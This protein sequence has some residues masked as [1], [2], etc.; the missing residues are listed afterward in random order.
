MTQ[1]YEYEIRSGL[2]AKD[3]MHYLRLKG[4]GGGLLRYVG[5]DYLSGNMKKIS[6][7]TVRIKVLP[8]KGHLVGLKFPKSLAQ[9]I[10]VG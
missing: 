3:R 9:P 8:R 4:M 10:A 7:R 6:A 2:S 1:M 5:D